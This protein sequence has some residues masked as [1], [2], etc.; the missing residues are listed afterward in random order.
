MLLS[1]HGLLLVY[2][3]L[4]SSTPLGTAQNLVFKAQFNL[5]LQIIACYSKLY[6]SLVLAHLSYNTLLKAVGSFLDQRSKNEE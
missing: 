6:S 4:R 1:V 2:L 5:I 3:P